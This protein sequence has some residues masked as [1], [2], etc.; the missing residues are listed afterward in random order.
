MKIYEIIGTVLP[1][2]ANFQTPNRELEFAK[3][4]SKPKKKDDKEKKKVK[5]PLEKGQ[6]QK[7]D[8]EI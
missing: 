3:M 5:S 2:L 4:K 7:V 8:F 6:G 1:S